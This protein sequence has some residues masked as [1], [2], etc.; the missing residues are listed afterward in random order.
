MLKVLFVIALLYML[1]FQPYWF[2]VGCF[3]AALY[4]SAGEVD[5]RKRSGRW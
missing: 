2:T 4:L 1:V 5:K 3:V